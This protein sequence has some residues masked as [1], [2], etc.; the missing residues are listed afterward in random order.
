MKTS[1]K[2]VPIG[3]SNSQQPNIGLDN[4]LGPEWRQAT[5]WTNE[6]LL[7]W[8]MRRAVLRTR[9]DLAQLVGIFRCTRLTRERDD[10]L[11][12]HVSSHVYSRKHN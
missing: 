2:F 10:W 6:G 8:Q 12:D 3:G 1:L 7:Y 5:I 9:R 4:G 11:T